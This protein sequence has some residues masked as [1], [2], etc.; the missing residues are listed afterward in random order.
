[1]IMRKPKR[2]R[3]AL[4]VES[5]RAYGRE[6]LLGISKFVREHRNWSIVFEEWR[7]TDKPPAWLNNWSGDGIIA[8]IENRATA[9]AVLRP[10][11]PVVDIRGSVPGLNVPLIDTDDRK[12]ARMAAEHLMER[13]FRC[14]AYCG[15]NG[16]NYSDKRSKWFQERLAESGF[17]CHVYSSPTPRK[18]SETIEYEKRGLLFMADMAR[19][20]KK[21]PKPAGLMACNDIRGQQ[22]INACRRLGIH[23]PDQVAVIG[24]DNDDV[25][26]ELSDPPMTS[27][28]PNAVQIGYQA[29]SLLDRMMS[30][31]TPPRNPVLV[32]PAG[33][34]TR[35]STDVVA[36]PDEAISRALRFIRE[37]ACDGI[38]VTALLRTASL[39]RRVM[40]RRFMELLGRS[41]KAEILRVQI[42][43]AK[44]LLIDTDLPLPV[45]AER[46]GFRY[47]EYFSSIFKLKTGITPGALRQKMKHRKHIT[48]P[49]GK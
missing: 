9:D 40:E 48:A 3:V 12:V 1:M 10:G 43:R 41:P 24:V 15:F 30:G 42:E 38:N 25:L 47:S 49:D 17:D 23:I 44:Q 13:G 8:R 34:V 18:N 36:I 16:A 31:R 27:I 26:C 21:L 6:V 14:F 46:T 4:L 45:I 20:L 11:V 32:E 7:W 39:S 33:I 35:H 22:V 28:A 5:S 37:H 19:W 2:R 29:A